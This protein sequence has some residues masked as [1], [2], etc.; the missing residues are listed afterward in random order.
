MLLKVLHELAQ[1]ICIVLTSMP[2]V[3]VRHLEVKPLR[4]LALSGAL[5]LRLA[6]ELLEPLLHEGDC[7]V[8]LDAAI[9][10]N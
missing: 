10:V 1:A 8:R 5:L 2:Q 3:N 9:L 6:L 7:P 4:L